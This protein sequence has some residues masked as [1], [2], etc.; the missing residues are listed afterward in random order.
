MSPGRRRRRPRHAPAPGLSGGGGRPESAR[1]TP[2]EEYPMLLS[3]FRRFQTASARATQPRVSARP[4]LEPLEDR[5]VLSAS[6]S[7]AF[8]I[9][10][11]SGVYGTGWGRDAATDTAGN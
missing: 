10:G 2:E 7:S 8:A 1:R 6:F 4:R 5:L 9:G 3:L 11:T